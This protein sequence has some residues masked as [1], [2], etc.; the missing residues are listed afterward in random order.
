MSSIKWDEETIAEHDK[1]RGTRQKINEP[2]T[3]YEHVIKDVEDDEDEGETRVEVKKAIN[4]NHPH[5]KDEVEGNWEALNAQ[6]T[7][8]AMK[9]KEQDQ[10][11][12]HEV[13]IG[14]YT[15]DKQ[16][17][18]EGAKKRCAPAE[19]LSPEETKKKNFADKRA[20]HYNEFLV[21]KAMK[22]KQMEEEDDEEEED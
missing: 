13:S 9:Q 17:D 8:E 14:E 6:L 1:L 20:A 12:Q 18:F 3:P 2:D 22:Q 19:G 11:K 4:H 15:E 16:R 7:Y 5:A 10:V 21:L